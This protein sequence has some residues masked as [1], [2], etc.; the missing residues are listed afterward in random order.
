MAS[1]FGSE[2]W[3]VEDIRDPD[4]GET[5]SVTLR[6]PTAIDEARLL[7]AAAMQT[8]NGRA[9]AIGTARFQQVVDAIVDWTLPGAVS[10][11]AI[12]NLREDIYLQ[13]RDAVEA[14]P[15]TKAPEPAPEEA[16]NGQSPEL[17]E[18]SS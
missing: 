7:D 9:R 10:R 8:D 5:W 12:E 17:A 2:Q 16:L 13:I 14:G 18:I 3:V 1:P 11:E 6:T 15:P 4:D